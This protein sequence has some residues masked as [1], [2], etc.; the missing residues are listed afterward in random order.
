MTSTKEKER[1]LEQLSRMGS[2]GRAESEDAQRFPHNFY[3]VPSHARALDPD[4]V[5]IVGP[6]G[7]GKTEMFRAVT[8]FQ[9]LDAIARNAKNIRLPARGSQA[10][11]RKG[12]TVGRDYPEV[13]GWN[14]FLQ[15]Y[16]DRRGAVQDVWLAYLVRLVWDE[17][18]DT[19]RGN[20]TALKAQQAGDV[21]ANYQAL[22]QEGAEPVLALDRLDERLEQDN[23]Y[24]F[25]VYDELDTLGSKSRE[26]MSRAVD[27]LVALWA[28][29]ARRWHRIRGKIFLRSDIFERH[30]LSGGPDLAKL[31]A[32][33][34]ELTWQDVDLY[35]MLVKRIANQSDELLQYCQRARIAFTED[36]AL[37]YVP[38]IRSIAD[39]RPLT[40]R[41][42]GPYMG[43][44][45]KKGYTYRWLLDHIRDGHQKALPRPL[46]RLIERAADIQM[47]KSLPSG[48]RLLEP[49]SLRQAL[50]IVSLDHV[51]SWYDESPWL[52]IVKKHLEGHQ[53][54]FE[55]RDL[56]R[57]LHEA[58]QERDF[59]TLSDS[60]GTEISGRELVDYM[61]ELGILRVKTDGRI[62][63][64]DL[65]LKGLGLKRKGGVRKQ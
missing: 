65:F 45:I 28:S 1:L 58:I 13:S 46:V 49:S 54:P 38:F 30:V 43:A 14:K 22:L 4:V 64:P 26:V 56:Q 37:G 34:V 9:L 21:I 18:D 2:E 47:K 23:R 6:R 24:L 12:F 5:L 40:E 10:S 16:G 50:D 44:N 48:T 39:A 11:W 33:R 53:V 61:I 15:E 3:P 19:A 20:M 7:S 63:V 35:A 41:L 29:Y 60:L 42:V 59:S 57:I 36:P 31:A 52:R 8:E 27:G 17:L 32:N 25:V 51:R 55:R 62:D